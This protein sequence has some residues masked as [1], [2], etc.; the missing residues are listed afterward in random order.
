MV[1]AKAQTNTMDW[2][3]DSPQRHQHQN[4]FPS[5]WTFF[6]NDEC[7]FEMVR[8]LSIGAVPLAKVFPVYGIVIN[9]C[10]NIKR[11]HR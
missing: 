10:V 9:K 6:V 3:D 4:S 7:S 8:L 5:A 2:I 11:A 1:F